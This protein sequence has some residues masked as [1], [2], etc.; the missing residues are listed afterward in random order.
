MQ[1]KVIVVTGASAGIGAVL[2]EQL[3]G[4]GAIVVLVARRSEVLAGVA[5]RCGARAMAVTAD[6]TSRAE[7]KRVIEAAMAE[8]GRID[9]WVNNAGQGISRPPSELTDEDIDQMM[10]I[11]VKSAFYGMQ[12]VLPHFKARG[13]G[14][15]VNISSMLGR[16][17]SFVPRTAYSASKHYLNALTASFRAELQ[18]THP[19]IVVSL[20]SPGVVKTDFG[21]NAT[22][23][24]DDSR[25]IPGGQTAEEVAAVIV[26]TIEHQRI[27]VYT[28]PDG[29]D[30]VV[31]Y[32]VNLG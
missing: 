22:H 19:G 18:P 31:Q 25:Q 23:G 9:V 14:Q 28:R 15:I 27:D 30:M 1:D 29:R 13:T 20:V 16:I 3:A 32:Y 5:A 24:G 17:P 6:V 7:V 11:N 4:R 21:L 8:H 26:D 10:T 2:S 12:E